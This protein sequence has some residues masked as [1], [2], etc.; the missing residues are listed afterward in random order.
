MHAEESDTSLLTGPA[1]SESSRL[2][3]LIPQTATRSPTELW[4][5]AFLGHF[6]FLFEKGWKFVSSN[7]VNK[8]KKKT[9]TR[10]YV[11]P[12]SPGL[13]PTQVDHK[14]GLLFSGFLSMSFLDICLFAALWYI[15]I[16][17]LCIRPGPLVHVWERL[18]L[19]F[20]LG[21]S[22]RRL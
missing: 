13:V 1:H 20:S 8:K 15:L 11:S 12:M 18:N 3:S 4:A 7:T 2:W 16:A 17:S 6:I 22:E 14:Q 5:C 19:S 10:T 21:I 9:K